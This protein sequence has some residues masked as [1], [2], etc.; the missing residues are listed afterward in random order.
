MEKHLA[1]QVLYNDGWDQK[2]IASTLK[3]S[4]QTLVS[5]KKKHDWERK[6]AEHNLARETAEERLWSLINYQLDV[7][8]NIKEQN[9][10]L[11]EKDRKLLD[12]GDIDGLAK[13]FSAVKGKQLEWT[14]YVR[15]SRELMEV[16]SAVD[17]N[18]SKEL[19]THITEFLN[20][21]RATL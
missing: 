15:V 4:E 8:N 10:E 16:I 11:P 1:A 20:K 2:E 7:L 18:L 17:L 14:N 19:F 5:W 6:K 12:K 13:M 3:V 9:L 21:K